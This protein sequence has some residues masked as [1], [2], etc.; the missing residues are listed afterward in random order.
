LSGTKYKEYKLFPKI[1]KILSERYTINLDE[2]LPLISDKLNYKTLLNILTIGAKARVNDNEL[3]LLPHKLHLQV[4]SSQG[5]SICS[6][7]NVLIQI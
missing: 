2:I 6:I 5:F 1:L 7:Q 4:R 3:P